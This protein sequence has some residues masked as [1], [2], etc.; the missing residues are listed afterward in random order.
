MKSYQKRYTIASLILLI[1]YMLVVML[2]VIGWVRN[3]IDIV[4]IV[5]LPMTGMFVLRVVGIF[6]FPL[7]GILGWFF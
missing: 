3:I 6:V 1:V 7:G 4:A 2:V 5:E